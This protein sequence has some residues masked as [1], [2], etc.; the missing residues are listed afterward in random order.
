ML[1]STIKY[2]FCYSLVILHHVEMHIGWIK[3]RMYTFYVQ[4][5]NARYLIAFLINDDLENV[6]SSSWLGNVINVERLLLPSCHNLIATRQMEVTESKNA[7]I[8]LFF[9]ILLDFNLSIGRVETS[10]VWNVYTQNREMLAFNFNCGI[11]MFWRVVDTLQA[12]FRTR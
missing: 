11:F 4:C 5:C 6:N 12:T 2:V 1:L 9:F 3:C 7:T 8:K 10:I